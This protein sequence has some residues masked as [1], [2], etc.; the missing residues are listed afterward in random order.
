MTVVR[1]GDPT[2]RA[3]Q[4]WSLRERQRAGACRAAPDRPDASSVRGLRETIER[5]VSAQ[6]MADVP[7]GVALSGGLDSAVIA[8]LASGV[9][10]GPLHTFTVAFSD[11]SYDEHGPA[12]GLARRIGAVPHVVHAGHVQLMGVIE[13]LG[14]HMDEPLGDPAVLPTFLLA[15]EARRHVKVML[16]GEGADELFGGYPTYLGHLAAASYA[17]WPSGLR[18]DVLEPLIR[19]WPSSDHKVTFEFLLKRFIGH[20][21]EPLLERHGAWF[22]AIPPRE[23]AA[24]AGPRLRDLSG[25]PEPITTLRGMVGAA[26]EWNDSDLAQVMYVDGF[27]FLGEGLL[28]KLDR[29]CMA[30]SLESRSPYLGRDVVELA[31]SMPVPWKVRGLV[32]KRILR[33][34]TRDLVPRD[35]IERR[36]RGL[37]VP[38]AG[39]FRHELRTSLLDE[40]GQERLDAEGLLD[41]R[42]VGR[43]VSDHLEHRA[44]RSRS[45][46]AL[47][48]LVRWYRNHALRK[49]SVVRDAEAI[50]RVV[51]PS[52]I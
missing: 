5:S 40:L 50:T 39:M 44:D 23:A 26:E 51:A 25:P 21:G 22:G 38:L 17:R 33:E 45:L 12:V 6:L 14:A 18:R 13:R 42:A 35:F 36:K 9:Q 8:T 34:A 20:A 49:P 15:E 4:W 52:T 11:P 28:T 2:P 3:A 24:L 47:F 48:S 19:A 16:G 32:G 29:V 46:W 1:A 7:L 27:T 43:L 41:G 30:C 10:P 37:S 31:A